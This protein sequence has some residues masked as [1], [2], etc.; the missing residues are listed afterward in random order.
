MPRVGF[1]PMIPVFERTKTVHALA[2]AVTFIGR[3]L[4][5]SLKLRKIVIFLAMVRRLSGLCNHLGSV[6]RKQ[7]QSFWP[8]LNPRKEVRTLR[9]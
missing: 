8:R 5:R 9:L 3:W 2:L 7:F 6:P 1:E 4:T